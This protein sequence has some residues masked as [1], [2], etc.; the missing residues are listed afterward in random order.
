MHKHV[1]LVDLVKSFPTNIYLQN[2][3]SIQKRTSPVKFAHMAEKSGKGSISNLSTK[4]RH[5]VDPGLPLQRLAGRPGSRLRE[6]RAVR[7]CT[8]G[9]RRGALS[10]LQRVSFLG[11]R[12]PARTCLV[13]RVHG[14]QEAVGSDRQRRARCGGARLPER[15]QQKI[16]SSR[17]SRHHSRHNRERELLS[18]NFS[19]GCSFGNIFL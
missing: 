18:A 3:A 10:T 7:G 8:A 15:D 2:L 11:R 14:R 12:V 5:P 6:R 16:A 13:L 9:A 17:N 19:S 1:N 4:V